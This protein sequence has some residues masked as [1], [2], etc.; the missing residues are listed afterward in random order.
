MPAIELKLTSYTYTYGTGNC[1]LTYREKTYGWT[2]SR[3]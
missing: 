1:L 2:C 3:T